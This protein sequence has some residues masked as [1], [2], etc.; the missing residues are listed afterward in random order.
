MFVTY[1]FCRFYYYL[2]VTVHVSSYITVYAIYVL[3]FGVIKNNTNSYICII[4]VN[5][6]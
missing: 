1:I 6:S 2:I 4:Y 3:P 5:L